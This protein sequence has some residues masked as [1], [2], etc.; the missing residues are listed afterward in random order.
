MAVKLSGNRFQPS[1]RRRHGLYDIADLSKSEHG[2]NTH[3]RHLRHGPAVVGGKAAG[4]VAADV[5]VR[6][7]SYSFFF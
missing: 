3:A 7:V 5:G 1:R 4:L 2:P 6:Q